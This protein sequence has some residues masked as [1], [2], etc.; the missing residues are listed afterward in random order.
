MN[1]QAMF[2]GS[3]YLLGTVVVVCLAVTIIYETVKQIRKGKEE[4]KK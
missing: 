3:L 4:I 1:Y 2:V